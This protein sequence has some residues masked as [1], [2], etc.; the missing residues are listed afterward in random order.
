MTMAADTAENVMT[1]AHSRILRFQNERDQAATKR[2][3]KNFVFGRSLNHYLRLSDETSVGGMFTIAKITAK[4]GIQ[5]YGRTTV[6]ITNKVAYKTR[7]RG[8]QQPLSAT[9]PDDRRS[10]QEHAPQWVNLQ[11]PRW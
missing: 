9:E 5:Y 11:H 6:D 2:R 4:N 7:N 10:A 8:H 3:P 1:D